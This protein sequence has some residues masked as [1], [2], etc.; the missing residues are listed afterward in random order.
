LPFTSVTPWITRPLVS[1]TT[2]LAPG[3]A[4]MSSEALPVICSA[5]EVGGQ[6]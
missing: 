6:I 5:G 2:A 1:S 4:A 3:A